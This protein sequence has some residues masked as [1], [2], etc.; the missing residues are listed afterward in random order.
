MTEQSKIK[1][2]I[3]LFYIEKTMVAE[4]IVLSVKCC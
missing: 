4:N 1:V 2:I 3:I